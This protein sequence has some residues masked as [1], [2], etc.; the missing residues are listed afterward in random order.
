VIGRIRQDDMSVPWRRNGY[1]Y[2][3]RYETGANYPI[4]A[5]RRGS[6]DAPEEVMLDVSALAAVHDF[7]QVGSWDVSPDNRLLAFTEDT[8]GRRQ[9]VLR[10]KDLV[11]GEML[12]DAVQIGRAHVELQS[13]EN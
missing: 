11:T 7:Y 1:W 8:V 5:R 6:M 12:A 9:F 13:R 4:H 10:V 3:S 2:Y